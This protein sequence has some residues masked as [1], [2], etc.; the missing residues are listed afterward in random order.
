M[1]GCNVCRGSRV[2]FSYTQDKVKPVGAQPV[3][4]SIVPAPIRKQLAPNTPQGNGQSTAPLSPPAQPATAA[5]APTDLPTTTLANPTASNDDKHVA[6]GT[7]TCHVVLAVPEARLQ[8][9]QQYRLV[10]APVQLGQW[11]AQRGLP[12]APHGL[13]TVVGCVEL[14]R[15]QT[16]ECKVCVCICIC[17]L[18]SMHWWKKC[19]SGSIT[20]CPYAWFCA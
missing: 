15:G 6:E 12:L 11:D 19:T 16:H 20:V 2:L 7:V 9:G 10:G 14:Q 3:S 18:Q 13:H 17:S 4:S 5:Q 1:E 8:P